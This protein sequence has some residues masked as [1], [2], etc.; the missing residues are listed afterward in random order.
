MLAK[1]LSLCWRVR[2][3]QFGTRWM[4]RDSDATSVLENIAADRE[5]V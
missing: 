5:S 3:L 4:S 2:A 1:P